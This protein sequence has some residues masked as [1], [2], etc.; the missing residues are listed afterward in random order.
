MK[1]TIPSDASALLYLYCNTCSS[2]KKYL[3]IIQDLIIMLILALT[4]IRRVQWYSKVEI[5]DLNPLV[6]A[7]P[8]IVPAT[9]QVENNVQLNGYLVESFWNYYCLY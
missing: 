9:N 8:Y 7:A 5:S 1:K 2:K 4:S 3:S 6:V